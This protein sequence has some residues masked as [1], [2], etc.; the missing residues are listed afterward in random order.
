MELQ[1]RVS[2]PILAA[3]ALYAAPA[4]ASS[5]D[6]WIAF[7]AEVEA[8]CMAILE[9]PGEIVV[10]VNPFGSQT[11]GAAIVTVTSQG[12]GTDRMICVYDKATK[13]AELT[14]PF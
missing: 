9:E 10:E 12:M 1:M 13:A 8:A 3:L 6:A 7:R 11:Y 4:T 2:A 5:E 14:A